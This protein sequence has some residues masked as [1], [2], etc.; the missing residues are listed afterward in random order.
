MRGR[1][2]F[3]KTYQNT[4]TFNQ[5]VQLNN[6]QSGIYMVTVQDGERKEVKKIVIN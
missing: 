2:V 4:G 5:N 6:V 3:E 1:L